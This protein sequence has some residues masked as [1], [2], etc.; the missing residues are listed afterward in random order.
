MKIDTF[1]Y[2]LPSEL[3]QILT[4]LGF[5]QSAGERAK[6]APEVL[7]ELRSAI[8]QAGDLA[9]QAD[10]YFHE[11]SMARIRRSSSAQ[12]ARISRILRPPKKKRRP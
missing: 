7:A 10:E 11:R 3:R 4:R 2:S 9:R 8:E 6:L 5:V 12:S 1:E